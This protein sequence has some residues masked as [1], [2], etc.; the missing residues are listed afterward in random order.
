MTLIVKRSHWLFQFLFKKC[1]RSFWRAGWTDPLNH[2]SQRGIKTGAEFTDS[3]SL[4]RGKRRNNWTFEW[5]KIFPL[6]CE[7]KKGKC[8][9]APSIL[10]RADQVRPISIL[11]APSAGIM[12]RFIKPTL[13][14]INNS[15]TSGALAQICINWF[16]EKKSKRLCVLRFVEEIDFN[17]FKKIR[18]LAF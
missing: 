14:P 17:F 7:K 10:N 9:P 4:S 16:Q 2:F 18:W 6:K 1:I 5:K 11:L 13:L 12:Q 8:R 3:S 15:E